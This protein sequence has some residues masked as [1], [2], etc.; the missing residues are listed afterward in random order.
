MLTVT[1]AAQVDNLKVLSANS[2]D[3]LIISNRDL[4]D[5][6]FDMT[7]R[8]ALD[9]LESD[10]LKAFNEKHGDDIPILVEGRVGI[11]EVEDDG[12]SDPKNYIEQLQRAG[13]TG[14]VVGGGLALDDT[15]ILLGFS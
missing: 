10:E 2:I 9:I 12:K 4:E 8:Q 15:N 14:A 11:I 13:A 6:S 3:G 1:S 7:G 5:F